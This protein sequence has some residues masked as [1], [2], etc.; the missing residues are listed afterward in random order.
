[1]L[2]RLGCLRCLASA[3]AGISCLFS[4]IAGL[5]AI[6]S[7]CSTGCSRLNAIIRCTFPESALGRSI[8]N[9]RFS[10]FSSMLPAGFDG[11]SS[12]TQAPCGENTTVIP[13]SFIED[14]AATGPSTSVTWYV[15]SHNAVLSHVRDEFLTMM[16]KEFPTGR[17][18]LNL[19]LNLANFVL[20]CVI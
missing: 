4:S 2:L 14:T 19:A 13:P 5:P 20:I 3:D 9:V 7:T 18:K 10:R 15:D 16:F 17:L 6:C 1:M 12:Q 11:V 8:Q